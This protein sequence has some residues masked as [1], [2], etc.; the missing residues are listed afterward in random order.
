MSAS[1]PQRLSRTKRMDRIAELFRGGGN[2]APTSGNDAPRRASMTKAD[3]ATPPPA[4]TGAL[5]TP[6][7]PDGFRKALQD[8]AGKGH[9]GHADFSHLHRSLAKGEPIPRAP[10]LLEQIRGLSH[11]LAQ[12]PLSQQ[13]DEALRGEESEVEPGDG[14][15]ETGAQA[16]TEDEAF[17]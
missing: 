15:T 11:L 12:R 7:T 13:E 10:G 14:P 1:T 16:C 2:P 4:V 3:R 8:S 5:C 6:G 17:A 9:Y